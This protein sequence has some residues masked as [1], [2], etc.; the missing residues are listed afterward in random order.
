M[1][2]FYAL[3]LQPEDSFSL[4]VTWTPVEEG[5]TRELIIFNANG[6]IKHQAILLGRAE[7][8]KKKKV[9]KHG[10]SQLFANSFKIFLNSELPKIYC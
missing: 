1:L 7:A 5:G 10:P 2:P 9:T 8:P 4:S 6:V 3:C